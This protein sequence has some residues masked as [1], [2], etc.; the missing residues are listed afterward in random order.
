MPR[1]RSASD[2]QILA[3]TMRAIGRHGP[4]KLTLAHVAA[5]AGLSPAALVQRFGS[6]GELL[7]AAARTGWSHAAHAFDRAESESGSPLGALEQA[8]VHFQAGIRD[9]PELANHLAM[10]QLDVADPALRELAAEQA[11]HV[12]ERIEAL[13]RAAGAR[14]E[15]DECDPAELAATVHTAYNGALVTWAIEGTGALADW[16]RA[17][18]RAVIDPYR[19]TVEGHGHGPGHPVGPVEGPA[20]AGTVVP[21][22]R[23]E[24]PA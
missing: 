9:R 17:R 24:R 22:P 11:V 19:R 10:L 5:E 23:T 2:A 6:K 13:L 12:R 15:L 8:L 4:T 14:G 1:P 7:V 16:V 20:T 3:A 21:P 18:V